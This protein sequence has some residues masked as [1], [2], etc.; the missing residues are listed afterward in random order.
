[1][2]IQKVVDFINENNIPAIYYEELSEGQVSQIIAEETKAEARV[3]NT[4]HNVTLQEINEN[5][6]YISLM[7]ENL[8]KIIKAN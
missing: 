4:L 8:N 5:K 6:D 3:F 7:E 1:M 2:K